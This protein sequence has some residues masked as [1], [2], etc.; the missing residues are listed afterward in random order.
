MATKKK[1]PSHRTSKKAPLKKKTTAKKSSNGTVRG[2]ARKGAGRKPLLGA[3]M[4]AGVYVRCSEEQ[5]SAFESFITDLN[6]KRKAK[7]YPGKVSL[8]TWLRE[9]ALKHSGNEELG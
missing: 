5:K 2:G 1:S 7:G 8:S 4:E 6:E 9:L 3:K